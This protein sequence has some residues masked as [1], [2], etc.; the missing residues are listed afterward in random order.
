MKTIVKA[1][2]TVA[3]IVGGA[4]VGLHAYT[5]ER[6]LFCMPSRD[7]TPIIMLALSDKEKGWTNINVTKEWS[8][9]TVD[10]ETGGFMYGLLFTPSSELVALAFVRRMDWFCNKVDMPEARSMYEKSFQPF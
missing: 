10:S 7:K 3:V 2:L 9:E 4:A 1:G 8:F 5:K 6:E